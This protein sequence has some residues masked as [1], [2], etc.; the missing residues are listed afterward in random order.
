MSTEKQLYLALKNILEPYRSGM[1]SGDWCGEPNAQTKKE[2][3]DAEEAL[4]CFELDLGPLPDWASAHNIAQEPVTYAQLFTRNPRR[5][6]N[7]MIF[8]VGTSHFGV[9]TDMGNAMTLSLVELHQLYEIGDYIMD[10]R[11]YEKRKRQRDDYMVPLE[12]D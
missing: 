2:I 8:Y 7:A 5:N 10:E 3:A 6:G 12:A 11:G 9:I 4:A 1:E